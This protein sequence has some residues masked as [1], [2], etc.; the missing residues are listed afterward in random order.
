MRHSHVKNHARCLPCAPPPAGPVS[1]QKLLSLACGA[2]DP[3]HDIV[4][5][6]VVQVGAGSAGAPY[7]KLRTDDRSVSLHLIESG[8]NQL[9]NPII[10]S[11]VDRGPVTDD[12]VEY[13][14]YYPADPRP[15]QTPYHG[16]PFFLFSK[17]NGW[18]GGGVHYYNLMVRGTPAYWNKIAQCSGNPALSYDRILPSLI[19]FE[20]YVTFGFSPINTAQ[21]GVNGPLTITRLPDFFTNVTPDNPFVTSMS[22]A[23]VSYAEDY[24]DP[25]QGVYVIAN[26][27]IS[28]RIESLDQEV[29][30]EQYSATA[31]LNT[32]VVEEIENGDGVG[33]DGRQ[34]SID[35]ESYAIRLI[36][37]D[38][39]TEDEVQVLD[40]KFGLG[41][42]STCDR[43]GKHA[44]R[45]CSVPAERTVRG[46]R[47]ISKDRI[48]DAFARERVLLSA[49][50]IG[51]V[52]ILIRSGIGPA[53]LLEHLQ[54]PVRLDQPNVGHNFQNHFAIP[55]IFAPGVNDPFFFTAFLPGEGS[56][57]DGI[58]A[59]QLIG[60]AF[61]FGT[62]GV[63]VL[64]VD[65]Q[66]SPV[67]VVEQ[68]TRAF[69]DGQVIRFNP[70]TTEQDQRD[71]VNALKQLGRVA[72]AYDQAGG[73]TGRLPE[74]PPPELYPNDSE[75]GPFGG[76]APDDSALLEYAFASGTFLNHDG[77]SVRMSPTAET[78]VI[79][80]NLD[81]HGI[82]NLSI[83]DL[84]AL[85][86]IADGN[87]AIP[88]FVIGMQKAKLDGAPVPF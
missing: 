40:R 12:L 71:A 30:E 20:R 49:G 9:N 65:L 79:D 6:D 8:R 77:G 80:G 76:L 17:G 15:F 5:A 61:F 63:G 88:A 2:R 54:I 86:N 32:D 41:W 28:V 10:R 48:V 11:D 68:R 59:Y 29:G 56:G 84:G 23:G 22:V 24:N 35:S 85:C 67:G 36:F 1:R 60:G 39:L 75:F 44:C 13:H 42:R 78:G 52:E 21:R 70:L 3:A 14:H 27:Q 62:P 46:V 69:P 47:Y 26:P 72:I 81:V 83:T 53:A 25:T 34:L 18:G 57:P 66:P 51:D 38:E 43:C 50:A 58:R 74:A 87:T 73:G 45:R 55:V 19:Y 16:G 37:D 4:V 64:A 82:A 33:V 7:A 31:W